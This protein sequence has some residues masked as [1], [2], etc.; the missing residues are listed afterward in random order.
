M[1]K[2]DSLKNMQHVFEC[3]LSLLRLL[4]SISVSLYKILWPVDP[5]LRNDSEITNYKI[6]VAN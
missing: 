6:A 5:L 2:L 4:V 3:K 1:F